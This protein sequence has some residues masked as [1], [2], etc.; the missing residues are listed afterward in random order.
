MA[1]RIHVVPAELCAA[2]DRHRQTAEY[3][4]SVPASHAAILESLDS[5][6]PIFGELREAGRE[7]LEHRH[8]CYHQ[9]ADD[10]VDLADALLVA[11]NAWEQ[12]EDEAARRIGGIVDGGR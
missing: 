4:R 7:L 10:H 5:L 11:A 8:V 9:Q 3:L 2:A 6:G 12:H 1:D